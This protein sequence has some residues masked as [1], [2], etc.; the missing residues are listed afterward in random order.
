VLDVVLTVY[1]ACTLAGSELM[2][3]E[4]PEPVPL[5]DVT[6]PSG[7]VTDWFKEAVNVWLLPSL[8]VTELGPKEFAVPLASPLGFPL[9]VQV[10]VSVLVPKE[11]FTEGLLQ[12]TVV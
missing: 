3:P 5:M 1:V 7:E 12:L 2:L 6:V 4:N 10:T 8:I 11:A 9:M